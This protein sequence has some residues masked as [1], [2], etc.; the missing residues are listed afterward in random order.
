VAEFRG[1]D[2][3]EI[4]AVADER[5]SGRPGTV[6]GYPGDPLAV[7]PLAAVRFRRRQ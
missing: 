3:E 5:A 1:Q 2:P 6:N 4:G 7:P